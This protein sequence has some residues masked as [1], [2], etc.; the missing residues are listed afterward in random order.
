MSI[1]FQCYDQSILLSFSLKEKGN[2]CKSVHPNNIFQLILAPLDHDRLSNAR[3]LADASDKIS[4]KWV[5]K[6]DTWN[7][8]SF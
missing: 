3:K 1:I 4:Q 5:M 8:I 6:C 7:I 2:K